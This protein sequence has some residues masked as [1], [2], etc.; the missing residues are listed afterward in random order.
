MLKQRLSDGYFAAK[1]AL[2]DWLGNRNVARLAGIVGLVYVLLVT[3]FG[4][5][6]SLTPDHPPLQYDRDNGS[7]A[8]VGT[9]TTSALID[10]AE[11]LLDKP[12]GFLSNDITPPGVLMDNMPA[13]EYGVLMQVRDLSR[14]MRESYS[15]SQ[16]QSQED[17]DLAKAEPRFNFSSNSWAVP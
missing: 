4:M 8:V 12:G 5:Y 10:V 7:R 14:A 9:A 16:S 11:I 15:R 17:P 3:G 1:E 13:W 2:Q 6:W